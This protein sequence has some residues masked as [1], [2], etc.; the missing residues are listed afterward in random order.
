MSGALHGD[1]D[2]GDAERELESRKDARDG[3]A[4]PVHNGVRC[5]ATE[6]L[7]R[8]KEAV[9]PSRTRWEGGGARGRAEA[10]RGRVKVRPDGK[11]VLRPRPESAS[12]TAES[13]RAAGVARPWRQDAP[14][15]GRPNVLSRSTSW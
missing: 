12:G 3:T 15:P 9:N 7:H 1:P 14:A 8:W 6:V 5:A 10:N 13:G 11:R 2:P 4:P